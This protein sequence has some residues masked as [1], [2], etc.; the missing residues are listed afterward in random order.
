MK[1][2][3]GLLVELDY[4]LESPEGEVLETSEEDEPL[5]FI[6]GTGELPDAV[7]EALAGKGAGDSVRVALGPNDLFGPYDPSG[8]VQVEPE[9]FPEGSELSIGLYVSVTVEGD[10]EESSGELEARILE[11]RPDAVVLDTNPPLAGRPLVLKAVVRDVA[12]AE[13]EEEG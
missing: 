10:D 7:E 2:E 11:V 13:P 5:A 1:I 12:E 3:P 9:L 6:F 4:V 8:I